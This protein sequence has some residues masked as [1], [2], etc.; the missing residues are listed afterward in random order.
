MKLARMT[1]SSTRDY[2][3]PKEAADYLGV[4]VDSVYEACATK[5]LKHLKMGHSTIRIR[6]EWIDQWAD[7][8]ARVQG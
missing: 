3:S 6:R 5:G 7:E 1:A 2:I 4:S 8:K